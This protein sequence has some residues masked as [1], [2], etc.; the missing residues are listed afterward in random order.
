MK[1]VMQHISV[2]ANDEGNIVLTQEIHDLN[3]PDPQ[4][5]ISPDQA[6]LLAAWLYEAAEAAAPERSDDDSAI[7]VHF[8]AKGPG[9][10]AENLSVY[11]NAHGMIIL[12]ID[13]DTFI[14]VS[15]AMAKRLRDQLSRAIRS[16]L[17][18]MFRPDAEA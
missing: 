6:P 3:E 8:Y 13:D 15:P 16:A 18:E 9:P 4:I 17:T 5:W 11:N 10:D 7:P 12:K 2:E 14:E 1:R